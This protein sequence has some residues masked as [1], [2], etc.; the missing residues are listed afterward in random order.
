[1]WKHFFQFSRQ[2]EQLTWNNKS[3]I[4]TPIKQ[5]PGNFRL[6]YT[7][8]H[9]PLLDCM[10]LPICV[11]PFCQLN[12]IAK[13]RTQLSS[14]FHSHIHRQNIYTPFNFRW[15]ISLSITTK[16]CTLAWHP[17]LTFWMNCYEWRNCNYKKNNNN[18]LHTFQSF[19]HRHRTIYS[20]NYVKPPLSLY[21]SILIEILIT[22]L[23]KGCRAKLI[24][25]RM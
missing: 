12:S 10:S 19:S 13:T 16:S 6:A 2:L 25:S 4:L 1:M 11:C 15:G 23:F 9:F 20:K 5:L 18:K 22:M 24:N 3:L 21:F 14:R 8:Y 7:L 17:Y